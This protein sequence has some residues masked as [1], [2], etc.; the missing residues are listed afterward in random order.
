MILKAEKKSAKR[1]KLRIFTPKDLKAFYVI[2]G[3]L[4]L[5]FTLHDNKH[6]EITQKQHVT[7][8][9]NIAANLLMNR[10]FKDLANKIYEILPGFF[11]FEKAG[12]VFVDEHSN[13]FFKMVSSGEDHEKY[14][15]RFVQFS[16]NAGV[17]GEVFK[18]S[19]ICHFHN[20]K[21]LRFYNPEIDNVAA[22]PNLRNCIMGCM[23]GHDDKVVGILQLGNKTNGRHITDTDIKKMKSVQKLIGMCI[24]AT[25]VVVECLSLTI[26]FKTTI[27]KA[28]MSIQQI[29]SAK[30]SSE[31]NELRGQL[32][33]LKSNM[34]EAIRRKHESIQALNLS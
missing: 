10:S 3:I 33:S 18:T 15:D 24:S 22:A 25:N 28:T 19:E 29:V 17:T 13:E 20:V 32:F 6:K 21:N 14:S 31:L 7:E 5:Y 2:S 27:D 26:G 9:T 34:F 16:L 8:L 12:I 11:E 30:G 4:S 1:E 23:L